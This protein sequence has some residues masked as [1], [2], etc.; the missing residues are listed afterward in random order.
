MREELLQ[1]IWRNRLFTNLPLYSTQGEKIL[2]IRAGTYNTNAGPDFLEAHIKIGKQ[3]WVGQ[4]EIHV[5]ASDWYKHQHQTNEAYQNVILHVVLEEDILIQNQKGVQIP[6]LELKKHIPK[7][8]LGKYQRLLQKEHWIACQS[9]L[10]QV[11]N[12]RTQMWLDRL[13]IERME[14]KTNQILER[15]QTNKE[16]W[17]TSLYQVLAYSFGLSINAE[18]FEALAK[19]L[20]LLLLAKHRNNLLQL[21][22][23]CFGQAS[24]LE[25]EFEEEYPKKLKREY[26][27]LRAKYQLEPIAIPWRFLRLR[28][29]NFPSLRLAQFAAFFFKTHH[30]FSKILAASS[31]MELENMFNVQVS[32]Y[33]K[34]HYQLDKP[35]PKRKKKL[36]VQT[37]RIIIMNAFIPFLFAYAKRRALPQYQEKALHFLESMPAEQNAVITRFK[38]IGLTVQTAY[39]S[40]ALLQL[41][42]HYCNKQKCLECA[43]GYEILKRN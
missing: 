15:L 10:P 38:Q 30:L 31:V 23:L 19:S 12:E 32:M 4:V 26:Q 42:K 7:H 25:Q 21:E 17:E 33:W 24:L 43:I 27:F 35:A 40:Q 2:I 39:E 16:N 37:R 1:Y 5:K 11:P 13:V 8:F 29:A 20:P 3:L 18:P 6:C 9:F 28:P 41:K 36:G 34:T 22:A 14:Q